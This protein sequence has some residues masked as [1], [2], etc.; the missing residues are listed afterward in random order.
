MAETGTLAA[1]VAA[2]AI[3]GDG[4]RGL[5]S[6]VHAGHWHRWHS[7]GL[8]ASQENQQYDHLPEACSPESTHDHSMR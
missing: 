6:H 1:H 8:H 5:L 7:E 3:T 2:S 4:L